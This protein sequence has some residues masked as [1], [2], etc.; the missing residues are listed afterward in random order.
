MNLDDFKATDELEYS[1]REAMREN[2]RR[3]FAQ[4]GRNNLF[5]LVMRT[6]RDTVKPETERGRW[7]PHPLL[8]VGGVLLLAAAAIF[9]YMTFF[10]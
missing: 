6:L 9:L 8:L 10:E 4:D 5:R 7:R 2:L 1:D 3:A